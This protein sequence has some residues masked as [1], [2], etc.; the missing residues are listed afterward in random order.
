MV[1][2]VCWGLWG[3]GG[4]G[5]SHRSFTPVSTT[6]CLTEFSVAGNKS[7]WDSLNVQGAQIGNTFSCN[8]L[9]ASRTGRETDIPSTDSFPTWPQWPELGHG[10]SQKL[11]TS[12]GFISLMYEMIPS[13]WAIFFWIPWCISKKLNQRWSSQAWSQSSHVNE[14]HSTKTWQEKCWKIK[15]KEYQKSYEKIPSVR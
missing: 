4:G 10:Q 12:R 7:S 11:R 6:W 1:E 5:S 13:P 3:R 8:F 9:Y 2:G 14:N 15:E